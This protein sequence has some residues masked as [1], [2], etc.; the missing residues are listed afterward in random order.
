LL[1]HGSAGLVETHLFAK[2][3]TVIKDASE[4]PEIRPALENRPRGYLADFLN[5]IRGRK[6]LADLTSA[7]SLRASR[8]ALEAQAMAKP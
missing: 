7:Q 6:D 1:I 5:E 8:L 3:V 2:E 4:S